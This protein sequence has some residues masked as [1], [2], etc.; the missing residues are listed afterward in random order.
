MDYGPQTEAGPDSQG[1]PPPSGILVDAR[2]L[3]VVPALAPKILDPQGRSVYSSDMVMRDAALKRGLAAY[4]TSESAARSN[5]RIAS[6]PLV[7]RAITVAGKVPADIVISEEDAATLGSVEAR[8]LLSEARVMVLLGEADPR[9]ARTS[10][11][12]RTTP[13]DPAAGAPAPADTPATQ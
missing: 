9:E 10:G 4:T 5:A 8:R 1:A 3:G 2:G 6:R 11:T 12:V 13:S 7:I